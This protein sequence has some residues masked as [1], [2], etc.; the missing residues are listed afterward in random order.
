M[1]RLGRYFLAG[2]PQHIIQ[3]GNNR[4]PI[5]VTHQD[6]ACF[7]KWLH[8]AAVRHGVAIHAYVL[9]PNHVHLLATPDHAASLPRAMQTLG[10][11]YVRYFNARR[12]RSGTLWDGRYRAAAI[13]TDAYFF[14]CSRYI[15]L[16]PV[17]AQLADEPGG[18]PWSSYRANALG[19]ADVLVQ[20]H[21]LY[22]TLGDTAKTRCTAYRKMFGDGLG[23]ATL[24]AL[25]TATNGGWALGDETFQARITAATGRRVQPKPRGR[26]KTADA[27]APVAS[28]PFLA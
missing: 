24:E 26:P 20:P 25:R 2:Q 19:A 1:A 18:Y 28:Q 7:L 6:A 13:D 4:Q 27:A 16:N 10:R 17:R 8:E 23:E 21:A 15:E 3:R 5:F 12:Q 9:M 11:R 14:K 22:M